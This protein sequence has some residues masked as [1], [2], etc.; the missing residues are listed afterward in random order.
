MHIRTIRLLSVLLVL[1]FVLSSCTVATTPTVPPAS[2]TAAE[3]VIDREATLSLMGVWSP[4]TATNGN[5]FIGGFPLS[6]G[7]Y[8]SDAMFDT[9]AFDEKNPFIPMLGESYTVDDATK[10]VTM[11]LREGVK[12]SDGVPI[13]TA[14][15]KANLCME[16]NRS[17]VWDFIEKVEI[18]DDRSI[19]VKFKSYNIILLSKVL[20]ITI[21]ARYAEY[22]ACLD[23]LYPIIDDY[24]VINPKTDRWSITPDGGKLYVKFNAMLGKYKPDLTQIPLTGPFVFTSVTNDEIVM[25]RNE[26]YWNVENVHFKTL[27]QNKFTSTENAVLLSKA[28][29]LD[30]DGTPVTPEITTQLEKQF[31]FMRTMLKPVANQYAL[32]FNFEKYPVSI[33]EVRKAIAMAIDR[34]ILFDVK[35]PLGRPGDPYSSGISKLAQDKGTYTDKS[36]M[37]TLTPYEYDPAKA[38]ALLE[39]IGWKKVDGKWANEKGEVVKL[40]LNSPGIVIEAEVCR[41]LLADFGFE[42]EYVPVDGNVMWANMEQSKHMIYYGIAAAAIFEFP[43]PWSSY[44]STYYYPLNRI[45]S[46]L[47][48]KDGAPFAITDKAGV[49]HDVGKIIA[50]LRAADTDAELR[51]LTQEMAKLTNELCPFATLFEETEIL[52]IYDPKIRLILKGYDNKTPLVVYDDYSEVRSGF[53]WSLRMGRLYKVK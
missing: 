43:D 25:K 27:V 28:G 3:E 44:N 17:Y 47:K 4:I 1:V 42:M 26:N 30:L 12:W 21:K 53:A 10:T 36:F 50:D 45:L 9:Q 5:F 33:P 46:S 2:P 48:L 18:V 7:L 52:R 6:P 41:D 20:G 34:T 51:S 38:T 37:D 40:E 29:K 14:D 24:R 23:L 11:K 16:L 19:S 39:S 15:V 22:K 8:C 31:P 49:V 13:T 32:S 35:K